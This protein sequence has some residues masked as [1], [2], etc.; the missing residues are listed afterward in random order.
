[1]P[2]S[3]N[4]T[5]RERLRP[6]RRVPEAWRGPPHSKLYGERPVGS[7]LVEFNMKLSVKAYLAVAITKYGV[8]VASGR[9]TL[10][11]LAYGLPYS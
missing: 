6:R 4:L 7:H 8:E 11:G 9:V 1:M 2:I 3:P 5:I 10:L